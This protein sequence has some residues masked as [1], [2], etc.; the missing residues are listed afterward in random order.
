MIKY[1]WMSIKENI[2]NIF[3]KVLLREKHE[4]FMKA[5]S[6]WLIWGTGME[7]YGIGHIWVLEWT[8]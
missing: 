4:K 2:A 8:C 3:T 6:L 5:M 7:G 1:F